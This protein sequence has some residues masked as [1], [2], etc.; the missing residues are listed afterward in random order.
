MSATPE[1]PGSFSDFV[2]DRTHHAVQTDELGIRRRYNDKLTAYREA[3]A[4]ARGISL[5]ELHTGQ[6]ATVQTAEVIDLVLD[7]EVTAEDVA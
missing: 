4:A 5:G 1:N 6:M 7:T 2:A 3:L